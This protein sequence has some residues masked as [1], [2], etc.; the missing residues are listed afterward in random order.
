MVFLAGL[1]V[2]FGAIKFGWPPS[3]LLLC[4]VVFVGLIA[5]HG[6][7]LAGL[8]RARAAVKYF[9][10][11]L[12]RLDDRWA[13]TGPTGERYLD[14][15]HPYAAD[16]DLFGN[17]SLFQLLS[18]AKTRL[19]EDELA[20]W[21]IS[22]PDIA[23]ISARQQAVEELRSHCDLRESLALLDAKVH[24]DFDQNELR[25][26]GDHTPLPIA[27]GVRALAVV[28][29]LVTV[30]GLIL[31]LFLGYRISYF[32]FPLLLEIA[33]AA[34]FTQQ[35]RRA[36]Q[37]A[38]M[39]N[40][41][42][43]M[44]SQVLNLIEAEQF[45]SPLLSELRTRLNTDGQP[46][47]DRIARLDRL[48][49]LLRDSVQNQLFFPVAFVLLLPLHLLHAIERWREEVGP[50]LQD[51]LNVVGQ[52]EALV[53]LSGYAYEHP[54]D[55]F[56]ELTDE[57]LVVGEALGHPLLPASQCVRNDVHL[58]GAHAL[59]MISGSNM[60]GKSTL[61]RT[62]GTNVVLALAGAPVRA[63]SLRLPLVQLG[64]AMRISDSLQDGRSLF[65]SV[66]RRLKNVVDLTSGKRPLLFLLDEI[67]QGTNSHD[68]RV[69]AEGVIRKL[70]ADGAIGVVT[71][72]DLA[73]TDIVSSL[74][75]KAVN[76][77]FEDHLEQGRMTFDYRIRPGV[78]Q[79][80]NALELMR[81][82]GL[83]V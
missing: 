75:D 13:G 33:L 60:S 65:Y 67:L 54:A 48:A 73:L 24:D 36:L 47:S 26:F 6:R 28:L 8:Q 53:S 41:G 12:A 35:I 5:W 43:A 52:F 27:A 38:D 11:G 17:G 61:L 68:R 69:G 71:T 42:L 31:W 1:V 7:I 83:D 32:V 78:V 22:P 72:H 70:V 3:L 64:T 30:S 62:I 77:H 57:L 34:C 44:L 50:R 59:M 21:L 66:V 16:L 39:A 2:A 37:N 80:S 81:M 76:C 20:N 79:K 14:A 46:P 55:P 63:K 9:D 10:H 51:W 15:D 19:G 23:T 49:R 74:P 18:R 82:M 29:A 58:G 40:S 4:V 25:E 56:P 45:K